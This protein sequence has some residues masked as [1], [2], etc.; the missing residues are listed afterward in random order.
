M[1]A[2]C[3]MVV[4]EDQM[5]IFKAKK[6][7]NQV[8]NVCQLGAEICHA[9]LANEHCASVAFPLCDFLLMRFQVV[10]IAPYLDPSL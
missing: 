1:I 4:D 5:S 2:T 7:N 8:S 10:A 3:S 6:T 9:S